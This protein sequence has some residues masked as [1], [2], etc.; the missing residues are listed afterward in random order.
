MAKITTGQSF[1]SGDQITSTKLNNIIGTA[2]LASDSVTGTTLNLTSGQLKVAIDGITSNELKS[3]ANVDANRAV[4][5]NHIKDSAI[6]EAKIA[7]D[8]VTTAKI[9]NDAVTADKLADT[10][11][12]AGS[13]TNTNLTVDAQGRITLASS[14]TAYA[15][16]R[17][18]T[19]FQGVNTVT[20][21]SN[22]EFNISSV[23]RTG[24]G[25]YTVT[26][27]NAISDP[28]VSLGVSE[29]SNTFNTR[30]LYRLK[31]SS[32]TTVYSGSVAS[33]D[34]SLADPGDPRDAKLVQIL[35]F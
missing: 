10:N 2:S 19:S 7:S 9:E 31:N 24:T 3:D 5:T 30:N 13:Y 29:L 21:N 35:I 25:Q 28:V 34:I 16:I 1:N 17:A 6:T 33:M 23:T 20:R 22:A 27:T 4:G 8:A 32:G 12:A 11:V 26:F 18:K 14:G 15:I